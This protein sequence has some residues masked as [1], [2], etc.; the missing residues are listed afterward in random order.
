M[1]KVL[2]RAR[3]ENL[4]DLYLAHRGFLAKDQIRFIDV[5][6]AL[7]DTGATM[8]SLPRSLIGQLGL[9]FLQRRRVRTT[10]GYVDCDLYEAVR[11]T[12]Q[13]REFTCDVAEVPD[14]CPVL[15]DQIP[16][17]GLD[18]VVDPA[19]RRLI[20]NPAHGGQHMIEL[21]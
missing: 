5:D 11:L 9:N 4:S 21:L 18:F 1:G 13:G 16:L 12:I 8:L 7:V 3:V 17:E 20:G 19:N 10:A 2:V 15:I 6:D 14:T